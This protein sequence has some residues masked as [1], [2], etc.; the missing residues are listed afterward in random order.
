MT[1]RLVIWVAVPGGGTGFIT[2]LRMIRDWGAMR[3]PKPTEN[4]LLHAQL[5]TFRRTH[6]L[7]TDGQA[8]DAP[9]GHLLPASRPPLLEIV[10][11]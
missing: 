11:S 9:G 2:L 3:Q 8:G 10:D 4:E 1:S 5:T 6:G 7:R